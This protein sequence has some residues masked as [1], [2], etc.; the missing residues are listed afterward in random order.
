[1]PALAINGR[2]IEANAIIA[3]LYLQPVLVFSGPYPDMM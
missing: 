3:Y 2:E 1:M